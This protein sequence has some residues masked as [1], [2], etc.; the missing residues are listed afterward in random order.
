MTNIT[1]PIQV[2]I[3]PRYCATKAKRLWVR[4]LSWVAQTGR[5]V[6]ITR[7][8]KLGAILVPANLFEALIRHRDP[9][10]SRRVAYPERLFRPN[11]LVPGVE[12]RWM[13][14]SSTG[15][16]DNFQDALNWVNDNDS[17]FLI[18]RRGKSGLL[19]MSIKLFQENW[20]VR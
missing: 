19:L 7:Q 14:L 10:T 11:G 20:R 1:R 8:G 18:T 15:V 17:P 6:E 9:W 2:L 12:H 4:L 16:R 13:Q 3:P 5:P